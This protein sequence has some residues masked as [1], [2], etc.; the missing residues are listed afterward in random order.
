[1]EFSLVFG[2]TKVSESEGGAVYLHGVS[3]LHLILLSVLPA[4]VEEK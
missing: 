1:M 4:D 2:T 3:T